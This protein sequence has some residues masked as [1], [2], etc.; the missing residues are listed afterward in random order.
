MKKRFSHYRK[1]IKE[2]KK[3][4][5]LAYPVSI[6]RCKTPI[7]TDGDCSLQKNKFYIRINNKLTECQAI[8]VLVHEYAHARCWSHLHDSMDDQEFNENSHDATWGVAYAECY[9]VWESCVLNS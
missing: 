9:R 6:R 1:C 7:E 8:D 4:L 3:K 5:K 2:L